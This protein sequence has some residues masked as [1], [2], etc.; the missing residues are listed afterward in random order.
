MSEQTKWPRFLGHPVDA[1]SIIGV[2]YHERMRV[3]DAKVDA[4]TTHEHTVVYVT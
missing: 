2:T 4:Y 3:S 1:L